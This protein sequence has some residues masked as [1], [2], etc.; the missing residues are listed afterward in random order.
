MNNKPE[1]RR[2]LDLKF[3]CGNTREKIGSTDMLCVR[4]NSLKGVDIT[5]GRALMEEEE[6]RCSENGSPNGGSHRKVDKELQDEED[7][8]NP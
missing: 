7:I 8:L 2:K 5:S 1:E 6:K 3:K 4:Y